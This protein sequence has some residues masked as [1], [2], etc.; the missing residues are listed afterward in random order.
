MDLAKPLT[1]LTPTVDA[2]VLA[3][4]AGADT[5]FTGR[6][7]HQIAGQHSERGVRDA[8]HR[9][10]VQ[11]IVTKRTAG[12]SNLFALNR[13]HMAAP[14]IA[15]LADLRTELN[16]RITEAF[17]TWQ[18]APV[19]GAMFGSAARGNMNTDSDI[20]LL[21]VRPKNVQ[22]D[23]TIWLSQLA[24]LAQLV[25]GWTGNDARIFELSEAEFRAGIITGEKVLVDIKAQAIV[26]FGKDPFLGGPQT[27]NG[28]E[29]SGKSKKMYSENESGSVGKGAAIPARR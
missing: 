6:Q 16:R 10:C 24:D 15:A 27:P 14:Y 28:K 19:T 18:I 13:A 20:D 5:S 8:L 9:L 3:V 26:L 4:L 25:T 23:D 17:A 2:A 22:S 29:R 21:I 12:A 11:G 1:L 7:I